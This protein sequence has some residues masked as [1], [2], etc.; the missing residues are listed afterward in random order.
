M[1][2][3]QMRSWAFNDSVRTWS[4]S[5]CNDG[6]YD[7]QVYTAGR[8][9]NGGSWWCWVDS[10]TVPTASQCSALR[11]CS[12]SHLLSVVLHEYIQCFSWYWTPTCKYSTAKLQV[13]LCDENVMSAAISSFVISDFSRFFASNTF[14]YRTACTQPTDRVTRHVYTTERPSNYSVTWAPDS[15][16]KIILYKWQ[17]L[18]GT[19]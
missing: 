15:Q 18:A 1:S 19:K 13:F 7:N 6:C 12:Q 8:Q 5:E 11:W 3:S 10:A 2:V 16:F 14:M 17:F 9:W 4:L